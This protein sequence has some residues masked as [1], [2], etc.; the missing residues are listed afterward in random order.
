MRE[1]PWKTPCRQRWRASRRVSGPTSRSWRT[2]GPRN[3]KHYASL[4]R[5]AAWVRA[6]W[7][8][9]GY[10]VRDQTFLVEGKECAN[11][12]IEIPGRTRPSEIVLVSAQYDTVANIDFAALARITVGMYGSILELTSVPGS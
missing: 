6:R 1:R 7:E 10:A 12:E 5:A 11:L 3:P 2:L 9:Q 8:A 4:T